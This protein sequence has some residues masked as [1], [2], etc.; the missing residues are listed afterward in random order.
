MLG[1]IPSTLLRLFDNMQS[2]D[3][4]AWLWDTITDKLATF[5]TWL[6]DTFVKPFADFGTWLWNKATE[7]LGEF[8][9]SENAIVHHYHFST[10]TAPDDSIYAKGWSHLREDRAL[11]AKKLKDAGF[12]QKEGEYRYPFKESWKISSITC[13]LSICIL[14]P[15]KYLYLKSHFQNKYLF[16]RKCINWTK[17]QFINS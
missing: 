14:F 8:D 7:K 13:L 11:L 4:G 3:I 1:G 15:Q 16:N 5:G 9:I 17:F 10:G 12:P 2:M 6:W